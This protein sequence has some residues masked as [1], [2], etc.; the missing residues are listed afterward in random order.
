MKCNETTA[1]IDHLDIGL[2]IELPADIQLHLEQ[3]P[4]CTSY[5]EAALLGNKLI[6]RLKDHVPELSRPKS[7]SMDIMQSI[8]V[9]TD[10]EKSNKPKQSGRFKRYEIFQRLLTAASVLLLIWFGVE[11]YGV[12]HKINQLETQAMTYTEATRSRLFDP[13]PESMKQYII[14]NYP[15]LLNGGTNELSKQISASMMPDFIQR[16]K[17]RRILQ[18]NRARLGD[19]VPFQKFS[20]TF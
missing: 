11:Q 13:S 20:S 8:G 15:L 14:S 4:A 1:Y 17:L 3:C 12:L 10:G 2:N 5:M 19:M 16:Q 6:L 7:L 18:S 9:L